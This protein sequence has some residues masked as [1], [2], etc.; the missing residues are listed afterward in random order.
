MYKLGLPIPLV[1]TT[2][3]VLLARVGG[4]F[5]PTMGVIVLCGETVH[6]EAVHEKDDAHHEGKKERPHHEAQNENYPRHG[7]KAMW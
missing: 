7:D 4:H 1:C 6:S 2:T 3:V 5:C